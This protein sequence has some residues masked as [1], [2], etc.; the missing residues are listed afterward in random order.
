[1]SGLL[2]IHG[3]LSSPKSFKARLL[4]QWL[5]NN[6]P[7]YK[8]FCPF[9]NPYPDQ[10]QLVLETIVENFQKSG[11]GQLYLMGS[12]LGGLWATWLA[13]KYNLK[14]LLINP[15]ANLDLFQ[16]KYINTSLKNYHTNDTYKLSEHDIDGFKR[17]LVESILRPENYLLLVQTGDDVLDYRLAA[18][19]YSM[20]KQIVEQGGD[21]SFVN[22][23]SKLDIALEFLETS[24]K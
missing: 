7:Q 9:L 2:Y 4:G 14:A 15:V 24:E 10:T 13:E 5:Q 23:E 1:M 19:K 16:H 8:F 3:F 6:R 18:K 21:H 11:S 17:V 12:S 22:L 20:S